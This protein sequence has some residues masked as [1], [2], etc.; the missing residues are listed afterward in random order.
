MSME[1]YR[2]LDFEGT[3]DDV[4]AQIEE[5]KNEYS[6]MK[7][8]IEYDDAR[9]SQILLLDPEEIKGR[10]LKEDFYENYYS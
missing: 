7:M 1:Y 5:L 9:E 4:I 6:G 10:G 8:Y 2:S 3:P